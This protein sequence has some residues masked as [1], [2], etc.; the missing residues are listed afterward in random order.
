MNPMNPVKTEQVGQVGQVK[1][2]ALAAGVGAVLVGGVLLFVPDEIPP[3]APGPEARA[4]AATGT[5]VPA[6]LPDLTALINNREGWL[7]EHPEDEQAWALLGQAYVQRGVRQADSADYPKA[8]RALRRAL[9]VRSAKPGERGGD[10]TAGEAGDHAKSGVDA[11]P[12]GPAAAHGSVEALTGLAS[13]AN[14]RHDFATARKWGETLR[15]QDPGRWTAYP[16]LIDAYNGLG[17]YRAAGRALDKLTELHSGAPVLARSAAVFRDRGWREDA[18]A[19]ADEA[20]ARARTPAEKAEARHT[21]GELAWERG[22]PAEALKHYDAALAAEPGRPATLAGRA[23]ALAALSR[24]DEAYRDY[25]T[26]LE[27]QPRPEYA[28]ELGE[29]Y[30][31]AGLDGD[32]RTQYAVLARQ[33][34]K[35]RR[36]GVNEALVLARFEADHG[37]PRAAVLRLKAEWKNGRRSMEVADALGWALFRAGQGK[38]ALTYA[39][40]ATDQG[41]RSALFS[42]HRGEIERS[43]KMHGPARRHIEEALRTNPHFS[44]LLAPKAQ[45]ALNKL[46]EPEEGGPR[47]MYEDAEPEGT[48]R[49]GAEPDGTGPESTKSPAT[50]TAERRTPASAPA[51]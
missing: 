21:Q 44:P 24:T 47:D 41:L 34:A 3:P 18:A 39:K 8:D 10:G 11:K 17:D 35:A 9:A 51:L 49:E 6:A 27:K 1:R 38:Q 48:E 45:K 16:V 23:R 32:A 33:T 28:L 13:L 22:E 19:K 31:S 15:K 26:A 36:D 37:N 30:D 40:K 14:A 5:G 46:G 42:Y 7:S 20:A 12:G 4:M 50:G 2:A 29:L 43:L 25:Q